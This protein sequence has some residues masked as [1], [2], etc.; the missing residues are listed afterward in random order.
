M[1]RFEAMRAFVRVVDSGSFTQAARQLGLHKATV[2]QQ[3]MALEA[4]LGVRLLTRTTRSVVPTAEGLAYHRRAGTIL[5]QIDEAETEL[6][7]GGQAIQ[8]HLRVDVPVAVGRLVLAPAMREF[9]DRH[10]GVSVEL[11]CSDRVVDLVGAGVDCALRGGELPDSGLV[12]RRIGQLRFV[13]CAAPRYI[14]EHGLPQTPDALC[15]HQQVGYLSGA[16]GALR[17]LRLQREGRC[18]EIEVPARIVT[19]DSGAALSAALDGLG[20][21]H[22]AEFV[23]VHHLASGALVRVLPAWHCP[24]LPIHWV[25]PTARQRPARVQAFIDWAQALLARRLG[26]G[27]EPA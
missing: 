7:Q 4:T 2:S 24:S 11:G 12:A 26:A 1:D 16:T 19:N 15:G 6:R 22:L 9:L 17:P 13:L 23:A 10:P 27:L 20:L 18:V 5:Q 21:L 3:V 14:D 25:T 8:G